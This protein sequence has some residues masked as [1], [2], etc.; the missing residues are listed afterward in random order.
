MGLA[1]AYFSVRVYLQF[2]LVGRL[3]VVLVDA[4][5]VYLRVALQVLVV[6]LARN[7]QPRLGVRKPEPVPPP[8]RALAEVHR[9]AAVVN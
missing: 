7:F 6:E 4:V 8:E 3:L 2:C 5:F 9:P 1:E